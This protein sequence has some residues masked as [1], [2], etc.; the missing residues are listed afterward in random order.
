MASI[1]NNVQELKDI[2]TEIKR[3]QIESK[4]LK[5]RAQDI[6]KNILSYLNEKE[7]PGLKYQNTA[8]IIENKAKRVGRSKKDNDS[9]AIKILEENG[10]YNAREILNK[11]KESGKGEQIQ[12]QKVKLQTL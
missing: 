7:Q 4:R 5:K 2:N 1:Q 11:I 12:M 3:L 9:N 10:V 8:I 6:E